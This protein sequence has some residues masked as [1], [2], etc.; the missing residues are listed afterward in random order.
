MKRFVMFIIVLFPLVL[1]PQVRDNPP[2]VH[3]YPH[4]L[5]PQDYLLDGPFGKKLDIRQDTFLIWVD[6]FPGMF[7]SHQ[8]AYVLISQEDIR[9]ERGDW[10]PVLNGKTILHNEQGRYALI[11]PF[12]LP[13]ISADGFIDEKI[14]VYV[15]PHELTS[16]DQL[17]DGSYEQLFKLEDNC[18][19]VW[20]DLL[21][22]AFFA[23]PT[24]YILISRESIMVEHGQWWPI[25]NGR[26]V[27]YGEQNKTGI[28]SPFKVSCGV[29]SLGKSN[30]RELKSPL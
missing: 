17:A 24:A 4:S 3:F 16:Q 27:L 21:P 11:S 8:T 15:Y 1:F 25:L 12:E 13:L 26:K 19:F 2:E 5:I 9:I 6:L 29:G 18:L 10:W 20:V 23:H 7:F 30:K 14:A 22:D 28:I